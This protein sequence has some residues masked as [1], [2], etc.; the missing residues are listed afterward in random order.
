MFHQNGIEFNIVENNGEYFYQ[1]IEGAVHH[2]TLK[3][4]VRDLGISNSDIRVFDP[5]NGVFSVV[6]EAEA[7]WAQMRML[8][9]VEQRI[10]F[11]FA[12]ENTRKK[13]ITAAD[14]W[15]LSFEEA[16]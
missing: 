7:F 1:A 8:P 11:C 15:A 13:L 2:Q 16:A 12:D 3:K 4:V 10:E 9:T 5:K 6:G 14:K